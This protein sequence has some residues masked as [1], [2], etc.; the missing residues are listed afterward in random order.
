M[1]Q[2]VTQGAVDSINTDIVKAKTRMAKLKANG[3]ETKGAAVADAA[4]DAANFALIV[5]DEFSPGGV[6]AEAKMHPVKVKHIVAYVCHGDR[7]TSY[8]CFAREC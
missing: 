6:A 1:S 7:P 8:G 3:T 4:A 5:E 2:P